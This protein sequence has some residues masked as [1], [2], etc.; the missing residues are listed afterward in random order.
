MLEF[1]V[2]L[3]R[4][5]FTFEHWVS[6]G[7]WSE[8]LEDERRERA[9]N[10]RWSKEFLQE[11]RLERQPRQLGRTRTTRAASPGQQ[12]TLGRPGSRRKP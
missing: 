5:L 9:N 2:R 12:V 10:E 3:F 11:K 6:G 4:N 8:R 1:I 7:S